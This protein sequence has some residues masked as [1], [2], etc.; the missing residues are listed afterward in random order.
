M[1]IQHT[2]FDREDLGTFSFDRDRAE[3]ERERIQRGS[4]GR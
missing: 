1:F 4:Y 2:M 3:A